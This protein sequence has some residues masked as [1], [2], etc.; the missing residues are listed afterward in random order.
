MVRRKNIRERGKI[1]FSRA[2][3]ELKKGDSITIVKEKSVQSKFPKRIQG[4]SGLVEDK[5]GNSYVIKINDLNKE[6]KFIIE[7]IH[8][9]KI[10]Q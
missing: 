6:K 9:R 10:K 2:F 3:Q 7:P 1:K 5:R 8:L 4:K